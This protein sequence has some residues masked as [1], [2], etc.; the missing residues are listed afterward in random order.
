MKDNK[1]ISRREL[2]RLMGVVSVSA[3]LSACNAKTSTPDP[4]A[5]PSVTGTH[6]SNVNPP[7]SL[8]KE[9]QADV[10]NTPEKLVS[11]MGSATPAPPDAAYLSAIHG[12][13]AATVTA[14]AIAAIGG[15]ERFVKSGQNVVIKPN[16]CTD[17]YPY[18]YAATTNPEVVAILVRLCLGAGASRVR[19]MDHPFGGTSESAYARSGI[20]DAVALAG[21]EMEI[22]NR[23]KYQILEIP[24]GL[25]IKESSFYKPFLDAD[26]IINV[27]IAKHHR[28]ARLTLGGKNFLGVIGYP[29]AMHSDLG[30]RVA[31]LVSKVRPHL[32]V[33]DAIRTLMNNGPTGGDLNDVRLT[34]MVVASH[35]IVAAD[36]YAATL[37]GLQ[38]SDIG[39]IQA[40][41][42]MGLG[43]MDL[44]SIKLEEYTL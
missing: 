39:Y 34:N 10:Q 43:S 14:A 26:V 41:A 33:V 8:I 6:T 17:Y 27:P 3:V 25:S 19:V 4:T 1:E 22:M 21:G 28:L 24:E 15:I 42:N 35:D 16:I 30:Q 36:A 20:G 5:V 40:A 38:G 7:S 12:E 31:D 37:F 32:T 23:N 9:T 2:L 18:E 44:D 29:A 11:P 13:D